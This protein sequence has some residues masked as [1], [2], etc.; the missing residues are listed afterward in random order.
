[1]ELQR[2]AA[3]FSA[4]RLALDTLRSNKTRSFLTVLGVIIGTGTIIG[5]GSFMTGFDGAVA[6]VLQSFG[7][8]T[9]LVFKFKIG[10][11]LGNRSPEERMRKPISY[12]QV[13]A[14]AERC[15]NCARVTRFCL[16][17]GTPSR[18]PATGTMSFI[19]WIW[20]APT[21][22]MPSRDKRN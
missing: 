19:S 16:R 14:V 17:P 10:V 3:T 20:A 15:Q 4:I 18:T 12:E 22:A 7:T 5:V 13:R 11:Q 1:M 9:L 2:L 21:K 8:D 6:G